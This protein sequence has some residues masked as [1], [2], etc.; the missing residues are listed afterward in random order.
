MGVELSGKR[1]EIFRETFPNIR[2]LAVRWHKKGNVDFEEVRSGGQAFGFDSFSVQIARPEDF[3]D[4]FALARRR[5]PEGLFIATSSFLARHRKQ[6]IDF[7]ASSKL[8]AMYFQETFVE[9][10]GLMSYS[11]SINKSHIATPLSSWTRSLK[12]QS[13]PTFQLSSQ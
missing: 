11:A 6:I 8:P 2:R 10:G 13:P 5:R 3:D 4:A 12:E 1:L 9:D 7:G